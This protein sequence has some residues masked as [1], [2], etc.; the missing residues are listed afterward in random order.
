MT[1]FIVVVCDP[2]GEG[3]HRRI[4]PFATRVEAERCARSIRGLTRAVGGGSAVLI[5]AC[6]ETVDDDA[7]AVLTELIAHDPHRSEAQS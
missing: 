6:V 5:R 3:V 7:D 1:R 2:S 4:G